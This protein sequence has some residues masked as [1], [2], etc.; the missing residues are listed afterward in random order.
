M[1]RFYAFIIILVLACCGNYAYSASKGAQFDFLLSQVRN[2]AGSA[3]G[4]TVTFYE[5]GT[6][7]KKTVWLDRNKT[8]VAANPYTL[9]SNGTAQIYGDGLYR[10]VIKSVSGTTLYDR[11]N[12]NVLDYLT[13]G[14]YQAIDA[15]YSS[16]NHAVRRIGSTQTT[17]TIRTKDFPVTASVAVP[18][19]L[20]LD[21]K[22]PGSLSI[23]AYTV[24]GLKESRPEWFGAA[25]DGITD[26]YNAIMAAYNSLPA[27]YGG[28]LI[29]EK[30]YLSSA[31]LDFTKSIHITGNSASFLSTTG[32]MLIK[33]ASIN[34]D[35]LK[36]TGKGTLVE[37]LTVYGEPGN[38]GD[39][40]TILGNTITLRNF[41]SS[42]AGN[43]GIR[44]GL[45]DGAINANSWR[46][47]TVT[48]GYNGRHGLYIHNNETAGT[49]GTFPN[50]NAGV[51]TNYIGI[52]N[53]GDGLN[54]NF[55]LLNTFIGC[56]TENN[57]GWGMNFDPTIPVTVASYVIG[58]D[59]ESN[60][61]GDVNLG[62]DSRMLINMP[63]A[64]T[65]TNLGVGNSVWSEQTGFP[66]Q[67][68]PVVS[69]TAIEGA[70]TY[71]TQFGGYTRIGRTANFTAHLVWTAHTGTGNTKVTLP[72]PPLSDAHLQLVAVS[73]NGITV[74]AGA[75]I[76]GSIVDSSGVITLY[77][78]S[79]GVNTSLPL[80]T[81]G[82]LWITGTYYL[83][84]P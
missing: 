15:D 25:G 47:D 38:G 64:V 42:H 41:F 39:N 11:D 81:S 29:L 72:F 14:A 50:V 66:F 51:A 21:F 46:L 7:T 24:T 52:Y 68:T 62:T 37:N 48:S 5:A 61:S 36:L 28:L 40:V 80:P 6:T 23:G 69:G 27:S 75:Q 30:K 73:S 56:L 35:F 16:L 1:K 12:I 71:T 77:T 57:T 22:Y 18:S 49:P 83:A 9:D 43:D 13:S 32:S 58:G 84:G 33:K 4:G 65:V 60:G 17:L 34:G 76:G 70:A 19:T 67:Y 20:T 63:H 10:V 59:S 2:I 3:A 79:A 54:Q 45:D 8:I 74:A 44:I 26:D 55:A 82:E 53:T 78:S 31:A